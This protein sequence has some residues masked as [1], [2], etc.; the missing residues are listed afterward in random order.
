MPLADLH[1]GYG[2]TS[3]AWS[4]RGGGSTTSLIQQH[5][6]E[7]ALLGGLQRSSGNRSVQRLVESTGGSDRPRDEEVA[8]RIGAGAGTG[9]ALDPSVRRRLEPV[10]RADLA[11]VQVHTGPEADDLARQLGARAFTSGQDIWFRAGVYDPSS[12]AGMRTL[13]H[14]AAHAVQ[15]SAGPVD[16]TATA[17]GALAVS[18]PGDRFELAA[19]AAADA[20]VT[21]RSMSARL[22]GDGA[23]GSALEGRAVQRDEVVDQPDDYLDYKFQMDPKLQEKFYPQTPEALK[24][25]GVDFG[26]AIPTG[27]QFAMK[28]GGLTS[29]GHV[30]LAGGA[31]ELKYKQLVMGKEGKP[32]YRDVFEGKGDFDFATKE[33]RAKAFA[34][35]DFD[36]VK[37]KALAELSSKEGVKGSAE[38]AIELEAL[39][40]RAILAGGSAGLDAKMMAEYGFDK[41][42]I[43][44]ML[45]AGTGGFSAEAL[46][47]LNFDKTQIDA[48]MK[49][50]PAGAEG[51]L[52]GSHKFSMGE[53]YGFL[54]ANSDAL[55][56]GVGG[57]LSLP[58]QYNL[59]GSVG[60]AG[61]T[62]SATMPINPLSFGGGLSPTAGINVAGGWSGDPTV[63]P[64]V[65]LTYV[66]PEGTK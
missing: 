1:R 57:K 43:S 30:N 61:Y 25:L 59:G 62:G 11:G 21:G 7:A 2:N 12:E 3:V 35:F 22:V 66:P 28:Q 42:S 37:I 64:T 47:K 14:E 39:K 60:T 65:A 18:R 4:I 51:S 10:L 58:G 40:L 63:T 45:G 31:G 13:A 46:A 56:A 38:A 32:E 23:S 44:A 16:G 24:L 8:Q 41:S 17:G 29:S 15:Q 50:G 55:G 52:K 27:G 26:S 54:N 53:I 6:P 9:Q 33:G 49:Y 36:P 34:S 20:A 5:R 19:D 48:M